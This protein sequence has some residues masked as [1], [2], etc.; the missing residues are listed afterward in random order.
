MKI[1]FD[2]LVVLFG[3]TLIA[4]VPCAAWAQNSENPQLELYPDDASDSCDPNALQ[5]RITVHGV[6]AQGIM[7]LELYNSDDGFLSK[8][9]RL[10]SIRDAAE[11]GPQQMCFDLIEPGTYA[12]AGYH[13]RDGDRKFDKKWNMLNSII[14]SLLYA[15]RRHRMNLTPAHKIDI[16]AKT[17]FTAVDGFTGE[18]GGWVIARTIL[19]GFIQK[20]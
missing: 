16:K 15:N 14:D 20:L 13:D 5:V 17:L 12:V 1:F 11:N 7:K 10:R 19:C 9:G 4:L 18:D 8:K 6:T 3:I 2:N